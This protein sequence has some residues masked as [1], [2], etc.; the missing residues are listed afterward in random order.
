MANITNMVQEFDKAWNAHDA[1]KIASFFAEDGVYESEPA[2]VVAKGRDA[3]KAYAAGMFSAFPDVKF[4]TKTQFA[5]G[6][7][8]AS[9][10]LMTGT[11]KGP[12]PEGP[13]ATGKSF[14]LKCC[15]INEFEGNLMKRCSVY[16]DM[17]ALAKQLGLMPPAPG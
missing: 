3:V 12:L 4:E 8:V 17:A 11:N 6:N 16:F 5:S 10:I 9:E 2:G 14:S 7:F 1:G 13:P 15:A